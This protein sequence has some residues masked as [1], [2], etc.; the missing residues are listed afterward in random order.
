VAVTPEVVIVLVGVGEFTEP[1]AVVLVSG[2]ASATVTV[3]AE[4]V[5]VLP[6][7]EICGV[8][9]TVPTEPVLVTADKLVG[10]MT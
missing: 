4:L 7:K 6:D 5:A 3:P 8:A 9:T 10:G 2:T 1:V